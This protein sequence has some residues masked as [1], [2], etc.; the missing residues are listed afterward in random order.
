MHQPG[1]AAEH[2]AVFMDDVAGAV[3]LWPQ[4][5]D[6]RRVVAGRDKADVLAV[7]LVGNGEAK[8][9]GGGA[10]V[11]LMHVAQREPQH[12]Q[13]L[14]R[15]RKQK[16]ALVA[17]GI[18]GGMKFRP[19]RP[20][21]AP[22]IVAG[23]QHVGAEVAGRS[24]EIVELDRLVAAHARNRGFAGEVGVGK[25]VDHRL[26]KARF[27]IQHVVRN[28]EMA[29]GAAGVSDVT[30]GAAGAAGG[31]LAAVV[32]ELKGNAD[33]IVALFEHERGGDRRIDAAGH[34]RHRERARGNRSTGHD[35]EYRPAAARRKRGRPRDS[36]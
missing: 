15:C 21:E 3:G 10:G 34:R 33:D 2:A 27:V 13:L 26:A 6:R 35:G 32:I 12:G 14:R 18:G 9:S 29:G 16:V 7:G 5:L 20:I 23:G 17:G 31:R 25:I 8:A 19:L 30:A 11:G 28:A 22:D 36:A 24:E 4:A 1:M